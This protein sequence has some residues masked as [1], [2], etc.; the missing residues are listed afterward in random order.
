LAV[1]S[2]PSSD[3]TEPSPSAQAELICHTD[4]PAECYP[5]IFSPTEEFQIVHDDQDLPSGLHVRLNIWTGE[6]EARLNTPMKEDPALEGLPVDQ[7]IVVVEHEPAQD[8]QPVIPA[9][10]PVYEPVGKVKVPEVQDPEF[11][12]AL[13]VIKKHGETAPPQLGHAIDEALTNLEDLS[14]DMYYGQKIMEDADVVKALLCILTQRDEEQALLRPYSERRDFLA[15]STLSSALQNNL[16]ALRDMEANWDSVMNAQCTFHKQ[17]L[18]DVL[19]SELEAKDR[20]STKNGDVDVPVSQ[21]VRPVVPVVGRLLKSD[22]I[23][24]QFMEH[25]VMEDFLQI[26]RME[27]EKPGNW[28]PS[29]KK[30]AQIVS[31][32]FLDESVGAKLGLWPLKPTLEAAACKEDATK[33]DDGCWEYHLKEII[34]SRKGDTEW[35][36]DLLASLKSARSSSEG[37]KDEL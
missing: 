23:R 32:N 20:Q 29:Q 8:Q 24:P 36:R 3:A 25:G 28:Y 34:Q 31:D 16:P 27:E 10:A 2:S 26:L 6:K 14:H 13:D 22:Q 37:N 30:I 12:A 33:L 35:A 1:A 18:R 15:S 21:W 5:K 9:G 11:G 7:S 4:N 19:L 17:P